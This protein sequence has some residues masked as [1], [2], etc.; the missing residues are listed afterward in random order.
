MMGGTA[1]VSLTIDSLGARGDGLAQHDGQT[2]YVP[3]TVP[4]DVVD[5]QL[6]EKR[7][8]GVAAD[9]LRIT[10]PGPG[11]AKPACKHFG[12]CG[13]CA[14]QHLDDDH[15]AV[16][17]RGL[18]VEAVERAGGDASV[19]A[20]LIRI[21]PGTRRR[22]ALGFV[23]A[24]KATMLGFAQRASHT[25]ID[26]EECPVLVPALVAL[27]APLRAVLTQA[28]PGGAKGD[29]VATLTETGLDL[30]IES[31]SQPNLK[32]REALAGFATAHDIARLSWRSKKGTEPI[33]HRRAPI[34]R[35]GGVP[36][37]L[38][39]GGFL[40][41]STEGE[42]TLA[43]L[44]TEAVIERAKPRDRVLDLYAG[45]GSFTFPLAKTQRVHAVEGDGPAIAALTRAV[46]QAS[47]PVTTETRD[48]ARKPL[49]EKELAGYV[50]A[51]FDPPRI[52]AASQ[53]S[54]L[55]ASGPK[56]VV[57]VSCNP[58]TLSRDARLLID[59]GYRLIRAVP[60]D[61]FLW[62][63]RLEAVAVFTR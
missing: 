45:S 24:G 14:V 6:G 49:R 2:V 42:T 43:R 30:V 7:A 1:P 19:V 46:G 27:L 54:A 52:G 3:F 13:G 11:R 15:Y 31:E 28:L 36:V 17:K 8:D 23:R 40:Q 61:Q 51:V 5:A 26:V 47:L 22:A 48:L 59:G 38:P 37:E 9:L 50:A 34:V 41:P 56:L 20:P 60:V 39:P 35:P 16:W 12:Q 4:G 44:V 21:A 18:L 58:A 10:T 62:S 55:A 57:A 32:S 33:A 29:V 25:L 53:A 63:A